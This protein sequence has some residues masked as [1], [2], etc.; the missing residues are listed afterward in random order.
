MDF[1]P[2]SS[3]TFFL[4]VQ[5]IGPNLVFL[6]NLRPGYP[7]RT[8]KTIFFLFTLVPLPSLNSPGSV[9]AT[10]VTPS[11]VCRLLFLPVLVRPMPDGYSSTVTLTLSSVLHLLAG[12]LRVHLLA[13]RLC[14]RV[15]LARRGRSLR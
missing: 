1:P 6:Y 4:R 2:F 5:A 11:V 15:R 14:R 12:L 10:L 3:H 8:D 7:A 13:S 9:T